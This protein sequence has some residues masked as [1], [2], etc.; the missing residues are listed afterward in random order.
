M[1]EALTGVLVDKKNTYA[2]DV[3]EI[4]MWSTVDTVNPIAGKDAVYT[5]IKKTA[6]EWLEF[7]LCLVPLCALFKTLRDTGEHD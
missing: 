3:L 4:E 1:G 2:D 5:E 7:M 6:K